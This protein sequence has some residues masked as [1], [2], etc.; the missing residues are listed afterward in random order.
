MQRSRSL[1]AAAFDDEG[2][3]MIGDAV[4]FAVDRD[5]RYG[6]FFDGRTAE[7]FKLQTGTWVAVGKLRAQLVDQF[8]GLIRAMRSSLAPIVKNW[9]H[10]S[11]P[12]YPALR[13]LVPRGDDLS[14]AEILAHP[15]VR[16]A[17]TEAP[18]GPCASGIRLRDAH[19]ADRGAKRAASLRARRD[20]RQGIDQPAGHAVA[21]G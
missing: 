4:K 21:S 20:Y 11:S 15:I 8:G 19:H 17:L 10:W 16:S 5:P 9:K 3:Y 13:K 6:F 18:G 12:F 1:T 7:N 2:F 14:D